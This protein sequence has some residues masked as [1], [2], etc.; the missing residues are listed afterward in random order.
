MF[1]PALRRFG[2]LLAV[3]AAATAAGSAILGLLF[4]A[5]LSRSISVGFYIIGSF[6]LL[7]GFFFGNRGPLRAKAQAVADASAFHLTGARP[8]RVA[9]PAEREEAINMSALFLVLGL[10]LLAIGVVADT[11]YSLI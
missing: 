1:V 2:L 10:A 5:S 11:R 7:G 6:L 3:I 9:T 4:G 8:V